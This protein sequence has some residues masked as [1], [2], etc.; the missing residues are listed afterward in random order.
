M[1][2]E[3]APR[4]DNKWR[5]YDSRNDREFIG[6]FHNPVRTNAAGHGVSRVM[7]IEYSQAPI[8]GHAV[9]VERVFEEGAISAGN[10]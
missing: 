8:I 5:R 1:A 7:S 3:A 6:A 9:P 2:S 10:I 4:I